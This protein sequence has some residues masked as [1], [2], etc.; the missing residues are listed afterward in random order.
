[1]PKYTLPEL[2]YDFG[3]LEPHISG[4]I[5]E[6][7]HGKHH[8]TYVKSANEVL[9]QFDQ[10][11]SKD[12][13]SRIPS[14]EKSLAFNL[15]GHILHSILWMNMIPK[16]G[17]Q[18]EG[19]LR[20]ALDRDFGGFDAFKKQ[21]TQVASSIMGSGW[22]ALVWEPVGGRLLTTQIYDHQSNLSQ[23]GVPL[24][25]IDAW[26]HAYYLQY[27]NQKTAFFDAVWNLWNWRDINQRF[28][29]ARRMKSPDKSEPPRNGAWRFRVF[30]DDGAAITTSLRTP[31][32]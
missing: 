14:L 28:D 8:A 2:P 16:G 30:A 3:A 26:E 27:K 20:A 9:E 7:H 17:G 15:S 32:R 1:M 18:P 31:R 10:A 23:G 24:M 6:L 5:I 29:D 13:L 21:L 22:A 11:R 25:V 12:D 4:Q 19:D